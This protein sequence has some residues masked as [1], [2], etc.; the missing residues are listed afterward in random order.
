MVGAPAASLFDH[1]SDLR[2]HWELAGGRVRLLDP[3]AGAE[4]G[5]RVRMRGPLGLGREATTEVLRAERPTLLE[6]RARVGRATEALIS[7]RLDPIAAARTRV[8]L[9]ARVVAA[10]RWDRALLAAGGR[11]WLERLFRCVIG[12]LQTLGP[13]L[14]ESAVDV[15]AGAAVALEGAG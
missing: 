3:D 7:W 9:S 4:R 13:S 6:G 11:F 10:D 2:T 12:R 8:E 14:G 15:R 1:L 5:G